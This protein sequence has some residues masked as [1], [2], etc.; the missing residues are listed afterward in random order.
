MKVLFITNI[1][2]PYRVDFFNELGKMC[3]LTVLYERRTAADREST[4]LS[5][6]HG[7]FKEVYLKGKKAGA[8][9]A[10]CLE[11]IKWLKKGMFDIYVVGGYSTPT[12]MLAIETL[13]HKK[14]PFVLNADGG[15]IRSENRL[16]YSIKKH[17][18]KKATYYLSSGKG[19]TKYL[20]YYGARADYIYEYP[21][22]SLHEEDILD[23][24][25]T[26]SEKSAYKKRL[27]INEKIM[28]LSVG[29]FIPRKGFD[30]LM[31]AFGNVPAEY[32]VGVY[33]VGG[34]P[35]E[36]YRE[37]REKL[38]L[39]NVHFVSFKSKEELKKY[40]LASDL[41]VLPTREDIWG[42]VINEAMACGLPVIT[43]DRCVAGL[44]LIKDYE[45]GFIIPVEN[46]DVFAQRLIELM[47]NQNLAYRMAEANLRTIRQYTIENMAREHIEIFKDIALILNDLNESAL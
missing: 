5:C 27:Q 25:P 31:G 18:V 45:N 23:R 15:F 2:S 47:S 34:E 11:V 39:N 3:D 7:F 9:N 32:G 40:Y 17:F 46:V 43:T 6:N 4:W 26:G 22:T 12:G 16:K 13:S 10:L 28:I 35:T 21:F 41:F 1:P 33:I 24:V 37:L 38:K 19:T 30:V 20:Q 42:L 14:I 36:E 8:D 29:Q 44:E